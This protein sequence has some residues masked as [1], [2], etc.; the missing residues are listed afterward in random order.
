[1][2]RWV[3]W[4]AGVVLIFIGGGVSRP[5]VVAYVGG[6]MILVAV[7]PWRRRGRSA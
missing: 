4:V 5:G 3:L 2:W 1:V 6:A 7:I